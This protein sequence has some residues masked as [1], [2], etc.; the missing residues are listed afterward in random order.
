[1]PASIQ[2]AS[3]SELVQFAQQML[4]AISADPSSF[5]LTAGFVAELTAKMNTFK[6]DLAAQV[7]AQ[8]AARA[9]TSAK[10]LSRDQLEDLMRTGRNV[11]KAAGTP[12]SMIASLGL[13][14]GSSKAPSTATVPIGS[15][16]TSARFRHV[17]HWT[18]AAAGNKR[19]PRGVLGCEIW[20]KVGDPEPGSEKDCRFLSVAASTPYIADFEAEDVGKKAHYILRWRMRDGSTSGLSETISA[21]ITG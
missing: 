11:T 3:D 17:I 16:D 18:D 4:N 7:A 1:M 20:V 14:A 8:A 15:V 9:K 12:E 6:T 19:R 5:G 2:H 10:N 13:P 21:T